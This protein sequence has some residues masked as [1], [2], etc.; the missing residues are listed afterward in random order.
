[1]KKIRIRIGKDG[2]T[3]LSVEGVQGSACV[4]LTKAFEEAIGDVQ[5][6]RLCKEYH[7]EASEQTSEQTSETI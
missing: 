6:R 1:M 3:M 7:E 2:K 4:D 5:E